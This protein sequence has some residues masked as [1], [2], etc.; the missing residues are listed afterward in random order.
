M[1]GVISNEGAGSGGG[2][3]GVA[4]SS[5]P[6][7]SW[8]P[9]MDVGQDRLPAY[10]EQG[11]SGQ[12]SRFLANSGFRE[13]VV[14]YPYMQPVSTVMLQAGTLIQ[15][16]AI[17]AIN[18]DLPGEMLAMINTRVCDLSGKWEVIPAGSKLLGRMNSQLAYG[19]RRAQ[20]TFSRL[21]F[22]NGYSQQF[23]SMAATDEKGAPGMDAHVDRHLLEMAGA[24]AGAVVL[25][26]AGQSGQLFR[27]NGGE[28][29]IGVLAGS[30]AGSQAQQM[31]GDMI[32]RELNRQNTLYLNPNDPVALMLTQDMALPP[33]EGRRCI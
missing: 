12:M 9:G 7:G 6:L 23:D 11:Q 2:Y 33:Y 8:R 3:Q 15:A 20:G 16:T 25:S 4:G 10:A 1:V 14:G 13:V 17:T 19:Q 31:G 26:A 24:F 29:N 21:L 28:T 32:N 30:A 22:P 27:G 18:T 5:A